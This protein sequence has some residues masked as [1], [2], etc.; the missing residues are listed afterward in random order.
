MSSINNKNIQQEVYEQLGY[1]SYPFPYTTPS[2]LETRARLMGVVPAESRTARVLELGSTFGG[3]IISQ[4]LFQPES[5]FVGV[6]LSTSQVDLGQAIIESCEI[7]N[8]SLI[9]M[10]IANIDKSFGTFDYIIVHGMYS[11]VNDVVKDHILRIC[12][13]NLADN[14]IAYISYNTF[15]GWHVME[16]VR[17]LMLFANRHLEGWTH[18]KKVQHAKYIASVIGTEI[19][20]YNDLKQ[21]NQ[22]FLQALKRTIQKDDYYVG[23]DH[24]E[25]HNDPVYFHQ[26]I[27]HARKYD[28]SYLCDADLTLSAVSTYDKVL[29]S[30]LKKL[31][32]DS[33]IEQEQYLDFIVDTSFRKSIFCK[34]KLATKTMP[35]LC[36]IENYSDEMV[37]NVLSH[38]HFQLVFDKEF[39][40]TIPDAVMRTTLD[41]LYDMERSFQFEQS[42]AI[43]KESIRHVLHM[44]EADQDSYKNYISQWQ[45]LLVEHCV[46]GGIRC[47]YSDVS[48]HSYEDNRSYIPSKLTKFIKITVLEEGKG[49]LYPAN[50]YNEAVGDIT[51]EDIHYMEFFSRPRKK[52]EIIDEILRFSFGTTACQDSTYAMLADNYYE[53]L[54]N[55]FTTLGYWCI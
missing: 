52:Y 25:P 28:L 36:S 49:K 38:F 35:Q 37:A 30:R 15:P 27:E 43:V 18:N 48:R 11:W 14:G 1:I 34:S 13:E 12:S 23:H 40:N 51:E 19:L 20:N 10:D 24:L 9:A 6:E 26:F 32:P 39:I 3:N 16:E 42:I 17:Q 55:R 46:K 21:K 45:H 31:A 47:M 50:I 29:N 54:V 5:T 41:K 33:R 22:K 8:V 53:A 4:A 2:F 44:H 7:P